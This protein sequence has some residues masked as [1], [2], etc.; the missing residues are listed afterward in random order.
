MS[1]EEKNAQNM[2][3]N[4]GASS[5]LDKIISSKEDQEKQDFNPGE[6]ISQLLKKLTSKEADV[7]KRRFGLNDHGKE[8][9]EVIGK[10][11]EVTRERIRQIE[12]LAIKKIRGDREFSELIKPVEHVLNTI[13]NQHGGI[14]EEKFLLRQLFFT[15]KNKSDEKATLFILCE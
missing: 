13:I 8:T 6:V 12:G 7:L 14:M 10:R 15:T 4:S 5:I 9:L 11:Y 2:E 1:E 3:E